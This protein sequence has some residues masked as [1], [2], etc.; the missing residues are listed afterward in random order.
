M[1]ETRRVKYKAESSMLHSLHPV[2]KLVC[3]ALSTVTV[4][5]AANALALAVTVAFTAAVVYLPRST[6]RKSFLPQKTWRFFWF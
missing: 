1:R 6:K 4:L 3:F 5:C 2:V